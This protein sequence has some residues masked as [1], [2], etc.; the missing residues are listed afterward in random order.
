MHC[1]SLYFNAGRRERR[2]I[3]AVA[4][5]EQQQQYQQVWPVDATL[6]PQQHFHVSVSATTK[7][8]PEVVGHCGLPGKCR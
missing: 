6:H 7:E 4:Q 3:I 8:D 5:Q 2:I 1:L